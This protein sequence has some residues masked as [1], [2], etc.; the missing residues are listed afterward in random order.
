MS[1]QMISRKDIK[2]PS[3]RR[4]TY[5]LCRVKIIEIKKEKYVCKKFLKSISCRAVFIKFCPS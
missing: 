1:I 5:I 3:S 4:I 2:I